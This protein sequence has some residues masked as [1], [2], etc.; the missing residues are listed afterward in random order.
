MHTGNTAYH[1]LTSTV[2]DIRIDRM[3]NWGSTWILVMSQRYLHMDTVDPDR[4]WCSYTNST[5]ISAS[6]LGSELLV[7]CL[8]IWAVTPC[9]TMHKQRP[10]NFRRGP[11]NHAS[12]ADSK[13]RRTGAPPEG[14]PQGHWLSGRVLPDVLVVGLKSDLRLVLRI[15]PSIF[16]AE[17]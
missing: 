17:V 9:C 1:W 8:T 14:W 13:D 6:D 2:L 15:L 16:L 3:G 4:I 11:T 10:R 7:L 5:I 12:A